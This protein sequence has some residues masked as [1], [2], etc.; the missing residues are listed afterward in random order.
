[1]DQCN[2]D[3]P[4]RFSERVYLVF[5]DPASCRVAQFVSL[6]TIVLIFISTVA[7]V[8]ESCTFLRS[9]PNNCAG[10]LV[11]CEPIMPKTTKAV[12]ASTEA[13][14]VIGFTLDY[15]AR[16]VTSPWTRQHVMGHASNSDGT[17]VFHFQSDI[18][19]DR[20][21]AA[22]SQSI[23]D[24]WGSRR[25]MKFILKPMNMVDFIAIFPFYAEMFMSSS[26]G[27]GLLVLRLLRL[28]RV[29]RLLKL[30]K[31]NQGMIIFANAF[32]TASSVLVLLM[33][34]IG[35]ITILF[36]SLLYLAEGGVWY[37]PGDICDYGELCS[38]IWPDGAYLRQ[39]FLGTQLEESPYKSIVHSSWAVMTTITTVGYGD[40]Y[41]TGAIGKVIASFSMIV[42]LL[43]VALPITVLGGAFAW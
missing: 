28:G 30:G 39:N 4:I 7:F 27:D 34:M 1:M 23:I 24:S 40:L 21:K 8:L 16:L 37:E 22:I 19:G 10:E 43:V 38:V 13:F 42:G 15:V 32:A 2:K 36:G 9:P 29:L 26:G 25:L 14:C 6:F 18:H 35:L 20:K 11:S 17:P 5:E 41:P 31:R 12:F 33:F 3:M